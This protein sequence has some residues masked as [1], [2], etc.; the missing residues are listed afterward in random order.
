MKKSFLRFIPVILVLFCSVVFF[1]SCSQDDTDSIVPQD[2]LAI[3]DPQV[4]KE[5]EFMRSKNLITED[6]YQQWLTAKRSDVLDEW[7]VLID[8]AGTI[9]H[10]GAY[11]IRSLPQLNSS[12]ITSH[13]EI[14]D[15]RMIQELINE[16]SLKT[17][18]E[19]ETKLIENN[20]NKV[21]S[22]TQM[23]RGLYMFG[24]SGGTITLRVFTQ[25]GGGRQAV[26]TAWR[27]ALNNA[28]AKWN[29]QN[30]KVQFNIVSATNTNIVGGYVNVYMK[31]IGDP[32]AFAQVFPP[33]T[34]GYFG[35]KLEINTQKSSP[36]AD[37]NGK[38]AI[39][40][41]EIG[42]VIGFKHTNDFANNVSVFNTPI[43][44][45]NSWIGDSFMYGGNSYNQIFND[46]NSCD[47]QNLQYYW[48][49]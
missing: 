46:F 26:N 37:T 42:H 2:E 18:H 43:L 6:L 19:T 41:H 25:S 11:I 32:G 30:L 5:I 20:S 31:D 7:D 4:K 3:S 14:I 34:A 35:E 22:S 15:R 1:L 49:Y 16:M 39:L 33:G 27:I 10:D 24:S 13:P 40:V 28:V 12:S 9:R 17:G 29:S 47:K 48:G 44:C 45:S 8:E 36:Q 38:I 21:T 23:K